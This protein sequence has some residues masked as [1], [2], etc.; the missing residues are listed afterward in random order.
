MLKASSNIKSFFNKVTFSMGKSLCRTL[1]SSAR[2]GRLVLVCFGLSRLYSSARKG[3]L[4]L[5]CL[6]QSRLYSL[7]RGESHVL[8][9]FGQSRL[10]TVY[11]VR[12]VGK[13]N[14]R[15]LIKFAYSAIHIV[16]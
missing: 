13:G 6:G 1:Y 8:V 10:Y 16:W 12:F 9:C 15:V 5:V 14:E 11:I 4:V 7:V 3:R 2:K